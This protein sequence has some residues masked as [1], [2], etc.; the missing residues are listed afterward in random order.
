MAGVFFNSMYGF[1]AWF[2]AA[3]LGGR[4]IWGMVI[5]FGALVFL[6]ER[7]AVWPGFIPP[8]LYFCLN[9]YE[10]WN[11]FSHLGGWASVDSES[12]WMYISFFLTG[13]IYTGILLLLRPRLRRT[14]G[15]KIEQ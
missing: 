7:K 3:V 4:L 1:V 9:L 13:N 2:G 14:S 6:T 10:L 15:E 8:V 11:I 5:S 12:I